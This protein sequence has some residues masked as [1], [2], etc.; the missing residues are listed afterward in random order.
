M[1]R[2]VNY[3]LLL[4]W[5]LQVLIGAAFFSLAIK[6]YRSDLDDIASRQAQPDAAPPATVRIEDYL[7]KIPDNPS[8]EVSLLAQWAVKMN[9]ELVE[10]RNGTDVRTRLMVVLLGKDAVTDDEAFSV[11]LFKPERKDEVLGWLAEQTQGVGPFGPIVK[12]DGFLS[13]LDNRDHVAEALSSAGVSKPTKV[14]FS[15]SPFYDG[16]EAYMAARAERSANLRPD[17]PLTKIAIGAAF[18]VLGLWKFGQ[19]RSSGSAFG[20]SHPDHRQLG[21]ASARQSAARTQPL[22]A[23]EIS[24]SFQADTSRSGKPGFSKATVLIVIGVF[25]VVSILPSFI[26]DPDSTAVLNNFLAIFLLLAAWRYMTRGRR[27]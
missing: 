9:T 22:T 15:I 6:D 20:T 12:L 4:P 24:R 26:G 7:T 23:S 18:L 3:I 21:D 16:R 17:L 2:I 14:I 19:S 1:S 10:T 27:G 13:G 8:A 11:I 25:V 5:F